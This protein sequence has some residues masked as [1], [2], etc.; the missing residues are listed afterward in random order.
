[1]NFRH[2]CFLLPVTRVDKGTASVSTVVRDLFA[3]HAD[4]RDPV[5][6]GCDNDRVPLFSRR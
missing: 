3:D 2:V 5:G 6:Q 1:M 4:T